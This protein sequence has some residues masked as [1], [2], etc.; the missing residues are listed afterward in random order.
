MNLI[1]RNYKLDPNNLYKSFR[2]FDN[3]T[4]HI[5]GLNGLIEYLIGK[6]REMYNF[7]LSKNNITDFNGEINL[8]LSKSN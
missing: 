6:S 8:L 7:S 3:I 4:N 5:L 1:Q 2:H